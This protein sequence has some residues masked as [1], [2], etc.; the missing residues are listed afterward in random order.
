MT[1]VDSVRLASGL[2]LCMMLTLVA[3]VGCEWREITSEGSAEKTALTATPEGASTSSGLVAVPAAV[4]PTVDGKGAD[5]AWDNAPVYVFAVRGYSGERITMQAVYTDTDIFFLISWSDYSH[6]IKQAGSWERVHVGAQFGK[7][8]TEAVDRW[9]RFGVEDTLS[10]IWNINAPDLER[11]AFLDQ[12]HLGG[13]KTSAGNMD[14]WFWAAGS[15][16]PVH[17][18]LDQYVNPN[19]LH[20]DSGT[21]F[22]LPNVADH[23]DPETSINETAYPAYMP[24]SDLT[25][26]KLPKLFVVKGEKPVLLYYRSEVE[27]F[28]LTLID[29]EATLP[30]SIFVD[31]PSGSVTDVTVHSTHAAAEEIWTLEIQRKR[32][33]ST[34]Q[35]DIQFDDLSR[36]Y[37]FVIGV[38]DNTDVDGSFSQRQQL[39]FAR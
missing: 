25:Q 32:V 5:E 34:P 27:P 30:G 17:R 8:S 28:T 13:V 35:E 29:R 15:T 18:L 33:T 39:T 23:D 36:A 20:D 10:L 6:S 22:L 37:A 38:F 16:D 19:G 3:L 21:S 4:A 11:D 14:R 31:N 7:A 9:E 24:R 12:M 1:M 26:R 2:F